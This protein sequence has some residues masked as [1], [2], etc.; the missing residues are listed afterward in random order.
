MFT[1]ADPAGP[2]AATTTTT[3]TTTVPPLAD[4][5]PSTSTTTTTIPPLSRRIPDTTR[6]LLVMSDGS[7]ATAEW[8]TVGAR[9][10]VPF[11]LG[12]A[13]TEARFNTQANLVALLSTVGTEEGTLRI[14][15]PASIATRFV[16]VTSVTWH[17]QDPDRIAFTARL[18]LED[19]LS[20]LTATVRNADR[21]EVTRGTGWVIEDLRRVRTFDDAPELAA[22][23]DWG[24]AVNTS[25]PITVSFEGRLGESEQAVAL[26]LDVDGAEVARTE[27]RVVDHLPGGPLLIRAFWDTIGV[28]DD[29][30]PE[31]EERHTV[32]RTDVGLVPDGSYEL[33]TPDAVAFLNP[34]GSNVTEVI[35]NPSGLTVATTRNFDRQ[36]NRSAS[37]PGLL[38]PLGFNAEGNLFVLHDPAENELVFLDWSNSTQFRLPSGEGR[39]LAVDAR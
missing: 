26:A 20:L 27:G 9:E 15:E 29:G 32:T 6:V 18:P 34:N 8:W 10:A 1:R 37:V 4:V 14:G 23:G 5:A 35:V 33:I 24:F 39:A 19:E 3:T 17:D 13:T 28:D 12:L 31:I 16:N 21:D 11:D 38:D 7:R 30:I 36:S 2:V 25:V 22:W